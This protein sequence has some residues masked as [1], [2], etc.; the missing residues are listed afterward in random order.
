MGLTVNAKSYVA[1]GWD[2]SS[3]RFQGPLNTV[4]VVDRILQ[5]VTPPKPTVEFSGM[6]RFQVKLNRTLTLTGAKTPSGLATVDMNFSVPVGCS[7]ADR[8][9][10][11]ADLGAYVASA[12]FKA[13]L[14]ALQPSG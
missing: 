13:A 7:D 2:T 1:D 3:V 14:K 6:A 5:K 4:S 11:C 12:A 9:A 10:L 8:D